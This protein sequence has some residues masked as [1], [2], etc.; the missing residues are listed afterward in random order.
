MEQGAKVQNKNNGRTENEPGNPKVVRGQGWMEV[1]R[2]KPLAATDE[3]LSCSTISSSRHSCQHICCPPRVSV[4]ADTHI[5]GQTATLTLTYLHLC[6][7]CIYL[8]AN[9]QKGSR[10]QQTAPR[11]ADQESP[12]RPRSMHRAPGTPELAYTHLPSPYAVC[13]TKERPC[14]WKRSH[15]RPTGHRRHTKHLPP[16][17][18]E[19]DPW[20]Q[21]PYCL[22]FRSCGARG[23]Q[24]VLS[25]HREP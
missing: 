13:R 11:L 4:C 17:I 23:D 1:L 8:Q 2:K 12:R 6:H 7:L 24:E 22:S 9:W 15:A 14:R 25:P 10:G 20:A 19:V 3:L 21:V 16:E 18:Q 5:P